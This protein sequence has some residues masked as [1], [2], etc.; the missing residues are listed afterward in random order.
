MAID[1]NNPVDRKEFAAM[2]TK[3]GIG[4][5]P[6]NATPTTAGVVKQAATVANATVGADATDLSTKFNTLLTNL[7]AAGI[8]V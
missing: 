7:R 4:G 1:K 5:A 3:L 8:I 6:A 2:A